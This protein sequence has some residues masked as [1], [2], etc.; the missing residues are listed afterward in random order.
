MWTITAKEGDSTAQREL[1]I[2]YLS[3]PELVERT[4]LPLSKPREVFK[5]AVIE[6]YGGGSSGRS[7]QVGSGSSRYHGGISA[8]GRMQGQAGSGPLGLGI[9]GVGNGVPGAGNGDT[10]LGSGMAGGDIRSDP[11]LMCVAIHWMEAAEQGGD[12]LA[13]RF[14]AQNEMMMG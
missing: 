5:Q 13:R 6:K 14:M 4:T 8:Q 7:G 10:G 9:T 1:A 3:N 12:E 2:F 11:T